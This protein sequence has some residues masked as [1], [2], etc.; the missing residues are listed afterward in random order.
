MAST[1]LIP[2]PDPIPV[3]WGW[4]EGLNIL[5]FTVHIALANVLVGGG[6][7]ALYYTMRHSDRTPA[8]PMAERLP[9][10][11]ALTVN[12][13]VAP[14]LFLQVLYGHLF[15]TS[16]ILSA[17]WW[18]AIIALLILGYYAFYINQ[19][20]HK[21]TAFLG[22]GTA[23]TLLIALILTSVISMMARPEAWPEYFNNARGTMLNLL[24]PTFLPRFL[25]FLL[26]SIALGG[27]FMALL[28]HFGKGTGESLKK[29][30]ETFTGATMLQMA[31]GLWWLLALKRP[32][33]IFLGDSLLAT[34]VLVVAIGLTFPT[35]SAGIGKKPVAAT[36]W[37]LA[38]ILAMCCVRAIVRNAALAP[39]FSP[40]ELVV[41][42]EVSPLALYLVSLAIGLAAL[43]YMLKLGFKPHGREG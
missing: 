34:I 25:H 35:L 23:M 40:R 22:A 37:V 42:G 5:T 1:T 19:H 36:G 3:A 27:L 24:E 17:V 20:K 32:V 14:L 11:F 4:F 10:I 39:H 31:T 6:I 30:M 15:Y 12:F 28:A 9:T 13:G 7:I 2:V 29:G 33:Q 43:A 18:L 21:G 8:A 16:A 26:A 38:T 41:T